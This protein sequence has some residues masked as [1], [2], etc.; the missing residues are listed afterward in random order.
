M[1]DKVKKFFLRHIFSFA[2]LIYLEITSAV[3]GSTTSMLFSLGYAGLLFIGEW[4]IYSLV[5][6]IKARKEEEK[7]G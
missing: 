2:L 1:S 6:Y 4:Y 5:K 7:N 3:A